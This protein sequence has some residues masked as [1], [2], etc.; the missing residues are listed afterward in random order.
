[1]LQRRN[2]HTYRHPKPPSSSMESRRRRS[3]TRESKKKRRCKD[4]K[5][6]EVE[7]EV[8]PEREQYKNNVRRCSKHIIGQA[9]KTHNV[10]CPYFMTV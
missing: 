2:K 3:G 9:S 7:P 8:D 10:V 1:M 5:E 6:G 4:K